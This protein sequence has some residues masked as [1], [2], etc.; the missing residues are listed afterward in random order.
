MLLT[1]TVLGRLRLQDMAASD[2]DRD[3]KVYLE[4]YEVLR[5]SDPVRRSLANQFYSARLI[6]EGTMDSVH[7]M[8]D[9][10]GARLL[11]EEILKRKADGQHFESVLRAVETQEELKLMSERLSLAQPIG[12]EYVLDDVSLCTSAASSEASKEQKQIVKQQA[13]EG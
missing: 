5:S 12:I 9:T 3:N 7:K 13:R 1:L 6:N 4:L 8:E 10:V 2:K 11:L